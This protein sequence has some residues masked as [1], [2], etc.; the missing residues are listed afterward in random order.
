LRAYR[1]EDSDEVV[2][3]N[4]RVLATL[5]LKNETDRFTLGD[6]PN[7]KRIAELAFSFPID[8]L[9]TAKL[10]WVLKMPEVALRLERLQ[11]ET[12]NGFMNGFI[13]LTFEH[14]GRFYFVDWKSNWLGPN[15]RAYHVAAVAAEMHRNFYTLQLCIY[16]VALHRYLRVRKPGYDFEQHFGGAFYIFLR[17]ID[18]AQPQ[19]GVYF[20]RLSRS[21]VEKLSGIFEP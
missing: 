1:I 16:S 9:T 8:S 13:D 4:I 21:F 5:P 6:V 15:T 7:E 14:G 3:D 2:V 11:F 18:P 12:L 20:Q 10:A 17:G 19:N